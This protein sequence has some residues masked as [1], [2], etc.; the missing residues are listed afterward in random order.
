MP[1]AF[2]KNLF[3][4]LEDIFDN[5]HQKNHVIEKFWNLKI[6]ISSFND[7]YSKFIYLALNLEYMSKI[8]I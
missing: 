7:F 4:Y 2:I 8:F 6:G 3:N 5:F 1:F